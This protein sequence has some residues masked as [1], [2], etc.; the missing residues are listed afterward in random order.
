VVELKL[1]E[2]APVADVPSAMAESRAPNTG[3]VA[4]MTTEIFYILLTVLFPPLGVFLRVGFGTQF[5]LSLLLTLL[6][7]V[8]GLVHGIWLLAQTSEHRLVTR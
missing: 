7:Y 6:A 5:W 8:P 2:R 4:A 3:D 1:I